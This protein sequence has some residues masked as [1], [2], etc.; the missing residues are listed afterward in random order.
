M[1]RLR[2]LVTPTMKRLKFRIDT[3]L[4]KDK[5]NIGKGARRGVGDDGETLR[6]VGFQVKGSSWDE[7]SSSRR[8]FIN[9]D[10]VSFRVFTTISLLNRLWDSHFRL[11]C[12]R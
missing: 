1:I 2:L 4:Q 9:L 10:S 6:I 3:L 11:Y 7:S 5:L 12:Y 8:F